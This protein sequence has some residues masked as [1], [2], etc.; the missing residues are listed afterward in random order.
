MKLSDKL[1]KKHFEHTPYQRVAKE[2]D[3]SA[4]FVGMIARGERKPVRGKGLLIR[5]R[6]EEIIRQ[7]ERNHLTTI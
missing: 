3:V 1:L 5:K 7:E 4:K 6:L 2:F